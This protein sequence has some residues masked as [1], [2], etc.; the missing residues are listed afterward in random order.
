MKPINELSDIELRE[1]VAVEVMGKKVR[2]I[3]NDDSKHAGEYAYCYDGGTYCRD[4][5]GDGALVEDRASGS[6]EIPYYESSIEAAFEVVG[7]LEAM[8]EHWLFKATRM[9]GVLRDNLDALAWAAEFRACIGPQ[10]HAFYALGADHASLP[11]AI[12][13]AALTAVRARKA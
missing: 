10:G 12:C 11:R 1:A 5:L 6:W 3:A 4:Y 7:K 8:D 13:I 9:I 2:A